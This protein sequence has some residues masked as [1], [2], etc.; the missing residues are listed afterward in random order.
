MPMFVK[1]RSSVFISPFQL[2]ELHH[3]KR[4]PRLVSIKTASTSSIPKDLNHTTASKF[5]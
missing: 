3:M 5:K 2:I 1:R 4:D